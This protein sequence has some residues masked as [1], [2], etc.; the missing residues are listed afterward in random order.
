MCAYTVLCCSGSYLSIFIL[1]LSHSCSASCYWSP[2]HSSTALGSL[3]PQS[4][5]VQGP[6]V[7]N[8]LHLYSCMIVADLFSELIWSIVVIE[9]LFPWAPGLNETSQ[10]H[11]FLPAGAP[12]LVHYWI[13]CDCLTNMCLPLRT[14]SFMKI[15]Y[16]VWLISANAA[17]IMLQR[18]TCSYSCPVWNVCFLLSAL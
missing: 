12:I 18:N 13:N 2:F 16:T 14:R 10:N 5:S 1:F 11:V 17:S 4:L 7:L 3:W 6:S 15:L 8:I 9:V